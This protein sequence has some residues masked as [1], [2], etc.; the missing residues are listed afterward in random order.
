[1]PVIGNGDVRAA[2]DVVRMLDRTGCQGVM[3]GRGALRTPWVFHRAFI[4]LTTGRTV[5]EPSY[6]EKLRVIL[7]HLELLQKHA[8]ERATVQCMSR[9]ISWYGKTMGH[10]RGLRERIRTSQTSAAMAVALREALR[11]SPTREN[12]ILAS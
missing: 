6:E 8:G 11:C 3:I 1:M 2:E 10:T 4:R 7:R 12:R 9:R 5:P